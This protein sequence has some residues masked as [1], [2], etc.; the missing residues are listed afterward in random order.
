[1]NR[2]SLL[3]PLLI[4]IAPAFAAPQATA[5]GETARNGSRYELVAQ[6]KIGD[7]RATTVKLV[8]QTWRGKE[9]WH[10][11][12]ILVPETIEY[13]DGAILVIDHAAVVRMCRAL[14]S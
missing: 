5:S 12:S 9:W 2:I 11:L 13:G 14:V 4:S 6:E 3:T 1:M 7:C 10:W 8:S